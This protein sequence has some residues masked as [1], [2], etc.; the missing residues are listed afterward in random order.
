MYNQSV[1]PVGMPVVAPQQPAY[2]E[3]DLRALG[4][5]FPNVEKEVI[6]SVLEAQN[7]NKDAAINWLLQMDEE[8]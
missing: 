5:M 2:S 8:I 1:M 6:R 4:D 3:Q 7:G